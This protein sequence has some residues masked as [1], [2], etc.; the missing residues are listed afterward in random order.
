MVGAGCGSN[1]SQQDTPASTQ[2]SAPLGTSPATSSQPVPHEL[3]GRWERVNK[4]PQL[5]KALSDPGLAAIA[6]SV[7]GDYFPNMTPQDLAKKDDVCDGAH[8]FVHSHFFT[9]SGAF[10][11]LTEELEQVDDGPYE[12]LDERRLR[13]GNS[14]IGAVFQY[15]VNGDELSLAPVL[16]EEMKKDAL[17]HPL[18]FTSAGWSIS[19]SYP[20]HVWRRVDC[21]GWC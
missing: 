17:T 2:E 6:P 8:P 1:E 3:V 13:I 14:D 4:C 15:D 11:S 12:I 7:V 20:G 18:T 5:I 9:D 10:G 16:T 21:S 19:V